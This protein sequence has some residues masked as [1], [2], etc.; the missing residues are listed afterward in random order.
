MFKKEIK[1]VPKFDRL[2]YFWVVY[3]NYV[4]ITECTLLTKLFY[5]SIK[6]KLTNVQV[7]EQTDSLAKKLLILL[8]FLSFLLLKSLLGMFSLKSY[9]S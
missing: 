2:Y 3:L 4:H 9:K 8:I 7:Q 1:H 5:R 6:N